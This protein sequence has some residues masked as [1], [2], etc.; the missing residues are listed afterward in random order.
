MT[1]VTSKDLKKAYKKEKDLHVRARILAV[2]MVCM[3]NESIQFAADTL[4]QCPTWVAMWWVQR[5]KEGGIDTT[6][7]DL[8]KPGRPPK[9]ELEKI[10]KLV[11]DA[12]GIIITPK[13]LKRTVQ[14]KFRVNYHITNIRQ[15]IAQA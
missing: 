11:S 15:D 3:N 6:F 10:A 1:T 7:V 4:L 8:P 9:I 5:F 14:K 12:D 13:K 2:N